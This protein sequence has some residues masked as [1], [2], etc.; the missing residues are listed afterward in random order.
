M[1]ALSIANI[2]NS[3]T[4]VEELATWCGYALRECA[5]T[6]ALV[7]SVGV[8]NFQADVQESTSPD[9]KPIIVLRFLFEQNPPSAYTGKRWNATKEIARS[10]ELP[11]YYL[12]N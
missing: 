4:T 3:I 9:G 6:Q 7:E 1:T 10:A 8:A 11:A 5:P 2:P 12:S